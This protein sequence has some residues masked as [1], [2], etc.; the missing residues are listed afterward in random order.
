[1]NPTLDLSSIYKIFYNV[2]TVTVRNPDGMSWTNVEALREPTDTLMTDDNGN[3]TYSQRTTCTWVFY[4]TTVPDD[5]IPQINTRITDSNGT[6]WYVSDVQNRYFGN[7]FTLKTESRAG[8]GVED[9]QIPQATSTTSSS[10]TTGTTSTCRPEGDVNAGLQLGPQLRFCPETRPNGW[11]SI[12]QATLANQSAVTDIVVDSAMSSL[13]FFAD[14]TGISNGSAVIYRN[15]VVYQGNFA[16]LTSTFSFANP[17]VGDVWRFAIQNATPL[18]AN[19]AYI[20]IDSV[21]VTTTSSTS[22]TSTSTSS[23]STT[24]IPPFSPLDIAGLNLWFDFGDTS[25]LFKD[26]AGTIPATA[27]NDEIQRVNDLSG[28]NRFCNSKLYANWPKLNTNYIN[29][30]S[31]AN[32]RGLNW[33]DGS[34]TAM[35]QTDVPLNNAFTHF[36]VYTLVGAGPSNGGNTAISIFNKSP[37]QIAQS[38][39]GNSW[40]LR[41]SANVNVSATTTNSGLVQAGVRVETFDGTTGQCYVNTNVSGPLVA[42]GNALTPGGTMAAAVP[43]TMDWNGNGDGSVILCEVLLYDSSLSAGDR[44]LVA[45]YLMNKWNI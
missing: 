33:G 9:Q 39:H 31:V 22:S 45:N 44:N 27:N 19:V 35:R 5:L 41:S 28:N 6:D 37:V 42:T 1:V 2:Q 23:T 17:S 18:F 20:D 29:G 40:N 38:Q 43:T 13:D 32:F 12:N 8:V 21:A 14:A 25:T 7:V 26:Q 34:R 10:T 11:R 30:R 24:T 15:G 36:Y 16:G 3:G 4:K